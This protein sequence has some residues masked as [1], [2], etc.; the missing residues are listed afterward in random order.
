MKMPNLSLQILIKSTTSAA[1][2]DVTEAAGTNQYALCETRAH[3]SHRKSGHPNLMSTLCGFA[4]LMGCIVPDASAQGR[5]PSLSFQAAYASTQDAEVGQATLGR[6]LYM[7]DLKGNHGLNQHWSVG[8][9][10][11]YDV[12]D[13]RW[14]SGDDALFA[15]RVAPWSSINRYNLSMSVGYRDDNWFYSLSPMLQYTWADTASSSDA[16]SW[17][18][19]ATAMHRFDNGNL[20]G[21]GAIYL[22]DIGKSRVF[23]F[24][25]V[26]WRLSDTFV[27]TN[28]FDA[29]FSGPAGLE[30]I[31]EMSP[32]WQLGVGSSRRSQRVLLDDN[33]QTVEFDEWVGFLRLGWQIGQKVSLNTYAGMMF[34][35][36]MELGSGEREK[37]SNEGALALAFKV[38]F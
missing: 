26:N 23:P 6:D 8:W 4:L 22:D 19:V 5:P 33:G 14:Q 27:L 36:E 3:N 2:E 38:E 37:L 25:A 16:Q 11:G 17:G 20:L 18:L 29:G 35:G 31:Y 12:L 28:P 34:N 9:S 24:V 32:A 15:G 13:Y 10:L 21:L 30:L 1:S 7:F